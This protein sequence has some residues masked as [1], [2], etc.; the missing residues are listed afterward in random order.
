LAVGATFVFGLLQICKRVGWNG[1]VNL[2]ALD[3]LV[4]PEKYIDEV[5]VVGLTT[6]PSFV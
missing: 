6:L 1:T 5:P 2:L 4:L 3:V